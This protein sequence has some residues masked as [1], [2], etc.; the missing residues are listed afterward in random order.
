M[1]QCA[2]RRYFAKKEL[3]KLK[4]EAR[5]VNKQKE[6]NKGLEI[7]I[8]S[9]QQRLNEMKEENKELKTQVEKGAGLG[10]EVEKLKK[11]EEESKAKNVKIKDL[12]EELRKVKAELQN[13]KDEKVDLVTEKVRSE[14]VWAKSK[15]DLLAEISKL[16]SDIEDSAKLVES[17]SHI[18]REYPNTIISQASVD[19][20]GSVQVFEC[21]PVLLVLIWRGGWTLSLDFSLSMKLLV[22]AC[23]LSVKTHFSFL[24]LTISNYSRAGRQNGGGEGG[25]TRGVRAG[26]DRLPEA[27]QGLQLT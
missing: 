12:E 3:K 14:E 20:E 10:E 19:R 17:S 26:E 27:A 6:L 16:K 5:S 22:K 25:D 13:E 7:K 8:V 18:N 1:V 15:A 9:L 2:V 24:F 21:P 23:R 4:I 11:T